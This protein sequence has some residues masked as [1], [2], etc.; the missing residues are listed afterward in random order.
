[1]CKLT[2]FPCTNGPKTLFVLNQ[3]NFSFVRM[4]VKPL[5]V[6]NQ[7]HFLYTNV[8]K[9]LYTLVLTKNKNKENKF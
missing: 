5:S 3:L 2:Q 1:M 8:P 7:L 6:P 4:A 9:T